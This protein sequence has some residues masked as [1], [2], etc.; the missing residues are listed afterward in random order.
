MNYI[1]FTL[2]GGGSL[3]VRAHD[4]VAAVRYEVPDQTIVHL[5]GL[6]GD[7]FVVDAKY[8]DVMNLLVRADAI[9][10]GAGP[11]WIGSQN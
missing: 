10:A 6:G 1:Q 3:F 2:Q 11:E 7:P 4:V 5:R 8:D 9:T